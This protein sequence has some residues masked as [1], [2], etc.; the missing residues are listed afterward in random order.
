MTQEKQNDAIDSLLEGLGELFTHA[1]DFELDADHIHNKSMGEY[2]E[3]I[4]VELE[5]AQRVRY[6]LN[7]LIIKLYAIENGEGIDVSNSEHIEI[8][9]GFARECI[10]DVQDSLSDAPTIKPTKCTGVSW[11]GVRNEWVCDCPPKPQYGEWLPIESAPKDGDI[12]M[13]LEG[14]AEFRKQMRGEK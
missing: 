8:L 7:G 9:Q 2:S 4:K 10:K 11:C 12:I 3:N 14:A 6:M 1:Y 5:R 13:F